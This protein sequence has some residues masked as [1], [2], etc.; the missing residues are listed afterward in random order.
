MQAQTAKE[1]RMKTFKAIHHAGGGHFGG[2]LSVSEMLA[3]LYFSVM[4]IDPD[5]PADPNRD[6][7]ILS[8]GHGG[9]ALYTALALRGYFPYEEVLAGLD[10][11]LSN[12]PKHVDRLKQ[13]GIEASTGPLGQGLSIGCGMAVR[14]LQQKRQNRVYVLSGDG[15]C[16]SGQVWEAAMTA[17]KYCLNNLILIIDQNN[18]QIDGS[19]EEI[20]PINPLDA[21]F[22][23]FGWMVRGVDGHNAEEIEAVIRDI[24]E[25]QK[26][27]A[28][29]A[30]VIAKTVKG[31]GISFMENRP[32]WHSGK[33]T[34]EEYEQ[35]IRE[36]EGMK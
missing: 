17:A 10:K 23:A 22:S 2:S 21:K 12:F 31:Y 32:E 36:L 20:M 8:K 24:Q 25:K 26:H 30:A 3:V 6:R 34:A 13:A 35:G 29:P 16:N 19:C 1:I 5:N 9:P 28:R 27:D 4:R 33:I 18:M 7:F 11:P 14:F 15:E